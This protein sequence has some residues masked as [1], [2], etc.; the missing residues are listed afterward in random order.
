LTV[1][2]VLICY[3]RIDFVLIRMMKASCLIER[4]PELEPKSYPVRWETFNCKPIWVYS[5]F[6]LEPWAI[7]P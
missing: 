4:K 6:F 3:D 2:V 5:I 7:Y 1:I